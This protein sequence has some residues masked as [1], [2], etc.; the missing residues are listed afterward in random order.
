MERARSSSRFARRARIRAVI[1]WVGGSASFGS[2]A[3]A[4]W[5]RLGLSRLRQTFFGPHAPASTSC[6]DSAN[7]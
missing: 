3:L 6:E 4:F 1:L 7:G 5:C 2:L